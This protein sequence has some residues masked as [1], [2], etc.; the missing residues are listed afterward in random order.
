M[1]N[2][3]L[4]IDK[5]VKFDQDIDIIILHSTEILG[6]KMCGL[7]LMKMVALKYK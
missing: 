6:K 7:D 3:S 1:G 5:I 4:N 2:K